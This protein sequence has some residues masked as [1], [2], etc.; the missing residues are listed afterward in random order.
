MSKH[1]THA[2]ARC[3]V[4]GWEE[5]DY[6]IALRKGREH[7]KKTGHWVT[8]EVGLVYNYNQ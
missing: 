2:L 6:T 4:C 3:N 7:V 8:V 1:K 5:Q